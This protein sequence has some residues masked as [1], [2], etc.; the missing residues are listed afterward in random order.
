MYENEIYSNADTQRYATYQ[1][2]GGIGPEGGNGGGSEEK[3]Q[4]RRKKGRLRKVLFSAGLGLMFGLFAGA[5]FYGVKMGAEMLGTK[6]LEGTGQEIADQDKISDI[7]EAMGQMSKVNQVVLGRD[8]VTEEIN[9]VIPAMVSIVNNYTT[10][11]PT[12]WG[13]SYTRQGASAGSGIIIA[14]NEEELLIV[15]NNH[16]VDETD[17]LEITFIDGST[18][19]AVIKGKDAEMDLA[20]ISVPLGSLSEETKN[21][22]AVA[23]LGDSDDLRLGTYVFAIGN[24]LGYGQTVSDGMISGLDREV[25]M[26]DGS[27]GTFLQ[28]TAAINSGNSGGALFTLDGKVIGINTGKIGETGVEGMGFAIP[29]STASPIISE[30]MERKIRNDK[31][32]EE[33][34]GYMGVILQNVTKDVT[35]L[36]GMPQGA[37]VYSLEEDSPAQKA[38]IH[39]KD[40]IV[41]FDGGHISSREDLLND[42]QYY[43]AGDTISVTVMRLVDGSYESVELEITLGNKPQE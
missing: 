20:V 25:R 26:E 39:V 7:Q 27:T 34:Q 1:T 38:G 18:A 40:V 31:V 33:E 5:G 35:Q 22:I 12:F 16:V 9:D 15:T 13:Q 17:E 3:G 30:L 2:Q 42:I 10:T 36:Y 19:K 41:K 37:F 23:A 28:T 43:K 11:V 24:A 6:M 29:I 21:Q 4:G 14:R 8:E 32:D